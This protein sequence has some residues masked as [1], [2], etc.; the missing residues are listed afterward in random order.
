MERS[1]PAEPDDPNSSTLN[2]NLHEKLGARSLSSLTQKR[3]SI[4]LCN[5]P[6]LRGKKRIGEIMP[7]KQKAKARKSTPEDAQTA[8]L[9]MRKKLMPEPSEGLNSRA[10]MAGA[11]SGDELDLASDQQDRELSLLLNNRDRKKLLAI[12]E[13]LENIKEGKYG[14]CQECGEQIGAGRLK[15]MPLANFCVDCQ[16]KIEKEKDHEGNSEE[17]LTDRPLA[18]AMSTEEEN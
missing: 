13:A 14:V 7:V 5:L 6:L 4:K 12:D 18:G 9:D 1:A 11:E 16:S 8:L 10:L 2:P 17:D 15:A 3:L